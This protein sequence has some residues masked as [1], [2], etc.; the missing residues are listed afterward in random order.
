MKDYIGED[1]VPIYEPY[2][3]RVRHSMHHPAVSPLNGLLNL[4]ANSARRRLPEAINE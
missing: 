1:I 3:S 4:S 2:T